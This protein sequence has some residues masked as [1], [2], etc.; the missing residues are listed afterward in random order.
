MSVSHVLL[1]RHGR[2]NRLY[3]WLATGALFLAQLVSEWFLNPNLFSDAPAQSTPLS[4]TVVSLI[5]LYPALAVTVKRTND[6]GWPPLFAYAWLAVS[7][8]WIIS[9][10]MGWVSGMPALALM[11]LSIVL[12]V[13]IGCIRGVDGPNAHGPNPLAATA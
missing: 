2:L 6:I 4:T 3:Y 1:S 10:A 8:F 11:A 5:C 13:V 9:D 7:G 12:C